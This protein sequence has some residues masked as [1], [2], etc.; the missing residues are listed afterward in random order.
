MSIVMIND[1]EL[2]DRVTRLIQERTGRMVRGLRV[3]VQEGQ[4]VL[5]G[6]SP[7]YYYKQLASHAAMEEVSGQH[8]ENEIQVI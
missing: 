7:S 2:V 1:E 3:D 5:R 6:L 8:V 4:I